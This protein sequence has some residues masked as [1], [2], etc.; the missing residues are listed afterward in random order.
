MLD[1][2][3]KT[4][5]I[6]ESL[7]VY[8]V[9]QTICDKIG[10]SNADEY[11]LLPDNPIIEKKDKKEKKERNI[12]EESNYYMHICSLISNYL[13]LYLYYPNEYCHALVFNYSN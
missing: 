5:I 12:T 13:Y 6:D 4:V 3:L 8:M 11:S 10:I 2:A 7:S 1:S 9:V